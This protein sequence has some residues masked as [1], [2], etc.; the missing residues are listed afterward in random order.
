MSITEG[1][2]D[3]WSNTHDYFVSGMNASLAE[4][5]A[6]LEQQEEWAR[7]KVLSAL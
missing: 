6:W 5:L 7:A 1:I 2:H 3:Y 4:P